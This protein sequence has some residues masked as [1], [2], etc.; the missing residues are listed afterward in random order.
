MY[1]WGGVP[2]TYVR[3]TT[4]AGVGTFP[5]CTPVGTRCFPKAAMYPLVGSA[6]SWRLVRATPPGS[7]ICGTGRSRAGV[8]AYS[9]PSLAG[10]LALSFLP[11][12][13][14]GTRAPPVIPR[15]W[16]TRP[17]RRHRLPYQL[18]LFLGWLS[19][20]DTEDSSGGVY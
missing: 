4:P 17:F 13:S 16:P 6:C 12:F 5:A 2:N 1:V 15:L 18:T 19:F 10:P 8:T 7:G 14:S 9:L 11:T 3:L 20:P